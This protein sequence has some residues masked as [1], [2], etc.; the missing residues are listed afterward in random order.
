MNEVAC[1]RAIQ[2]LIQDYSDV[3]TY[4]HIHGGTQRV[5]QSV[6]LSMFTRPSRYY[7][8]VVQ[9]QQV[10]EAS[11]LPPGN[12]AKPPRKAI[13]DCVVHV[14]DPALPSNVDGEEQYELAH[15]Y[16]RTMCDGIAAMIPGA[17]W[18]SG[19]IYTSYFEGLPICIADPDSN[20]VFSLTRG[21]QGDRGVRVQN[22]DTID[23]DNEV[24]TPIHY[25]QISFSLEET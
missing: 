23:T 18:H 11:E 24:W 1:Q 25:S 4:G 14:S 20:S 13:Y 5:I 19:G 8:I 10:R 21:R 7:H 22:M 15:T 6:A 12:M 9:V 2:K 16:F 3:L 17:E